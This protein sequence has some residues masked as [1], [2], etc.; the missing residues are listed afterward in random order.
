[1]VENPALAITRAVGKKINKTMKTKYILTLATIL[2]LISCGKSEKEIRI[3]KE[4]EKKKIELQKIHEQK[5][6]IGKRKR[7]TELTIELQR[8]PEIINKIEE[9]IKDINVFQIG[10]LQSTKNKQLKK[11]YDQLTEIQQ[12]RERLKNEI[13]LLEYFKTFEFQKEPDSIM[14]YIF[15]S[16]KKGDFSDFRNLCDPYGEND[17]DVRSICNA[18][19]LSKRLRNELQDTFKNGRIIGKAIIEDDR[20]EIEFAYGLSS[21]KLEKMEMIKRNNL[22]YLYAF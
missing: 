8:I 10:R 5:V 6:N 15:E 16:A 18:E 3:E 22:W 4:I 19:I 1:V 17:G 13:P 9:D 20:A 2:I 21:N 11:A 12:H 14:K 7:I